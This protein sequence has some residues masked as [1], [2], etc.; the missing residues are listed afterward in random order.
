MTISDIFKAAILLASFLIWLSAHWGV[1]TTE[2]AELAQTHLLLWAFYL[3][4]PLI[5]V[6]GLICYRRSQ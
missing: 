3:S 1:I 5:V 4:V 6:V 2:Q